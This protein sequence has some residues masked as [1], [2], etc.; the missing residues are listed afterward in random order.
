MSWYSFRPYVSAAERRAKAAKETAR[1]AKK[2]IRFS[3]IAIQGRAIAATFWGKAWCKHIESFSDFSNR[4][5]RGRT[6]VRNGSVI[7]LKIEPR[8]I[9]AQ[10]IGFLA[11]QQTYTITPIDG[12]RWKSIKEA[13]FRTDR[14]AR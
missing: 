2:G 1:M 9:T 7:D 3:P 11:I 12:K 5:P 4:L 10:V 13:L 6:Y 14:F 8:K